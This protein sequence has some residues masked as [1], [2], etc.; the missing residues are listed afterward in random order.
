MGTAMNE[1]QPRLSDQSVNV[2]EMIAAGYTYEQILA[3]FP[4]LT[5]LDIFRAAEEALGLA[6]QCPSPGAPTTLAK[7]RERYPRA[8]EAWTDAENDQLR[9]LVRS[10]ATVARIAGQ[11]QRNRG[12]IRSRILKLGLVGELT[13]QEQRRFQCSIKHDF[14]NQQS[15]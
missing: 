5:Y 10:G 1:S 2:L 7:K 9:R 11:L 6:M 4:D 13:P 8:Y 15:P 3:I 14:R 12:A